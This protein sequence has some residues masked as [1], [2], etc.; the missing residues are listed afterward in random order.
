MK[1]KFLPLLAFGGAMILGAGCY[2]GGDE[3]VHFGMPFGK[4]TIVSRYER[5]YQLI[6]TATK[7]VLKRNGT[8]TNDD[9]VTKTIRA[10]IDTN[11]VWVQLDD[12]EAKIVRVSVQARSYGGAPNVALASEID[13]QIYGHLLTH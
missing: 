12:S 6:Y 9:S 5:P 3:R 10:Q 13:K 8:V 2:R 1:P 11:T 4:D 7:E